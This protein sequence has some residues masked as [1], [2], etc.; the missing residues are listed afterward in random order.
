MGAMEDRLGL[1]LRFAQNR[2]FREIAQAFAPFDTTPLLHA[3]LVLIEANPGSRQS[4]LGAALVVKQ[5]NLVDRIDALV[6][7]GL[8]VRA[9]DPTDGRANVLSLTPQGRSHLADLK[10]VDDQLSEAF[11]ERLGVEDHAALIA[12]LKKLAQGDAG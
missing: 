2:V 11:V 6:A 3:L 8:V 12:L 1:R 5:P 9:P 7:R 10:K 4:D